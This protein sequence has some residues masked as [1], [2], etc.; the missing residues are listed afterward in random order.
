[1]TK[2]FP[3]VQLFAVNAINDSLIDTFAFEKRNKCMNNRIN[4]QMLTVSLM[5]RFSKGW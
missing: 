2:T 1:M 4:I 3:L 5:P